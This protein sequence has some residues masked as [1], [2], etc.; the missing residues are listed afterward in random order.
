[1]NLIGPVRYQGKFGFLDFEGNWAIEPRFEK[2]GEMREGMAA[3]LAGGKV[4]F[5]D[6]RGNVVIEPR[7]DCSERIGLSMGFSERLS[8]VELDGSAGYVD[9]TGRFVIPPRKGVQLWD[10]VG[11]KAF[12]CSDENG[13]HVID[14]NGGIISRFNVYEVPF[15]MGFP[16]NWDCFTC[17]AS[18]GEDGFLAAALNW[19]GETVIPAIFARLGEFHQGTASFCLREED[20]FDG[21]WGL[22]KLSGGVLVPPR[23]YSVRDFQEGLAP[24]ALVR[25]QFGF[26]NIEGEFLI[27]PIYHQAC[28]FSEG[29]ACVTVPGA[30]T[31]NK[32]FINTRG[33]L[34]IEPR[35]R[36]QTSFRN[37][38]AEVEFEDKVGYIDTTGRIIWQRPRELDARHR[39]KM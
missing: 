12:G 32:G 25:K 13:Y 17:W 29:L 16:K 36:R 27:P 30:G 33:E 26:I 8:V 18:Y 10:F 20:A 15:I 31:L 37:G 14:R 35:Y 39:L 34:V 7:F 4:G 24:A 1:M 19:K 23:F 3:F 11:D 21:P 9:R 38:F 2:L 6:E 5:I 28:P 22:V